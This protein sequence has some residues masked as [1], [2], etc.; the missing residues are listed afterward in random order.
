MRSRNTVILG[1]SAGMGIPRRP[2]CLPRLISTSL[3]SSALII[4][5]MPPSAQTV[6]ILS[7]ILSVHYTIFLELKIMPEV[8][9]LALVT[10]HRHIIMTLI[11]SRNMSSPT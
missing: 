4:P 6:S 3:P 11:L 9:A 10:P 7:F 1:L 2:N 5:K 8:L